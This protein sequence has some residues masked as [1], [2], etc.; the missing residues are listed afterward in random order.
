MATLIAHV[1][2][3]TV[4]AVFNTITSFAVRNDF[5]IGANEVSFGARASGVVASSGGGGGDDGSRD[6]DL[7]VV[8]VHV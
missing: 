6:K 7:I 4:S 2:I 8:A 1:F 3:G 5:F